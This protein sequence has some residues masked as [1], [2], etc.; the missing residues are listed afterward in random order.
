MTTIDCGPAVG[1]PDSSTGS[2]SMLGSPGIES[3]S[4]K[5]ISKMLL[6]EELARARIRET[7]E[8]IR[9][10]PE[11]AIRPRGRGSLSRLMSKLNHRRR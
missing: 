5:E 2:T 3:K 1:A 10:R 4:H 11:H 8:Y 9:R 6:H 7:E